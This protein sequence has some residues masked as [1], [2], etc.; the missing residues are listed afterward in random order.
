MHDPITF[1]RQEGVMIGAITRMRKG[2]KLAKSANTEIFGR[3]SPSK[4]NRA[5]FAKNPD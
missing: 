3:F 2:L 5:V 1:Q 4:V